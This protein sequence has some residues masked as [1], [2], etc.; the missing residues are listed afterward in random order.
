MLLPMYDVWLHST[1][2]LKYFFTCV[3]S[4]LPS[5]EFLLQISLLFRVIFGFVWKYS[6]YLISF[7]LKVGILCFLVT[8]ST[9]FSRIAF[10]LEFGRLLKTAQSSERVIRLFWR[11]KIPYV[12]DLSVR[13]KISTLFFEGVIVLRCSPWKPILIWRWNQILNE[14]MKV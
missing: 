3:R 8:S 7:I 11:N 10:F 9:S 13:V 12:N 4:I 5:S 14:G 6:S 2:L 1:I